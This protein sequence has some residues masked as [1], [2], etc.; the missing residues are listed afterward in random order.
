MLMKL[1]FGFYMCVSAKCLIF[2]QCT[3]V[4][5]FCKCTQS[6]GSQIGLSEG[7]A[8]CCQLCEAILFYIF[9]IIY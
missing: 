7:H 2:F 3:A 8:S 9:Q 1:C 4:K 6:F 5:S